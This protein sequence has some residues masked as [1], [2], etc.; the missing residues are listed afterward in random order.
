MFFSPLE[1]FENY[2]L[3]IS[4]IKNLGIIIPNFIPYLFFI[5]F[6]SVVFAFFF[7]YNAS[8]IINVG[9]SALELLYLF[10]SSLT[11]RHC[12]IEGLLFFPLFFITFIF[13]LISNVIG[14]VP[15]S[16]TLT[17][18]LIIPVAFALIFNFFSFYMV[19]IY[20]NFIF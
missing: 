9:N 13:I 5:I 20:I 12:N 16:F 8:L 14:L 11:S 6:I 1:Q 4:F 17:S 10:I 18:Q 19:F 3:E 7:S 15:F 2:P